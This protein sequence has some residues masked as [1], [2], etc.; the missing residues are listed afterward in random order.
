VQVDAIVS[1]VIT[2]AKA[3]V[4]VGTHIEIDD[5]VKA[6]IVVKVAA[7]ISVSGTR[8]GSLKKN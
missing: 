2:S 6:D 8:N 4:A 1:V 7:I 5:A 3:V